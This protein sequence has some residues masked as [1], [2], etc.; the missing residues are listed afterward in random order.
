MAPVVATP[1]FSGPFQSV[2]SDS[3][4][5]SVCN[6]AANTPTTPVSQSLSPMS[7]LSKEQEGRLSVRMLDLTVEDTLKNLPEDS[8]ESC[9]DTAFNTGA[10]EFL[11]LVEIAVKK[12]D[13]AASNLGF[14]ALVIEMMDLGINDKLSTSSEIPDRLNA[15]GWNAAQVAQVWSVGPSD[16][17]GKSWDAA[18]LKKLGGGSLFSDV[19][20][21]L[22]K[23]RQARHSKRPA[24]ND[25]LLSLIHI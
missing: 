1:V 18:L 6:Y 23:N 11:S 2:Q 20:E 3:S 13:A 7:S 10:L 25:T 9:P 17:Q 19:W 21:A 12:A 4:T 22:K 5:G 16:G 8:F 24:D 14:G 15:Q